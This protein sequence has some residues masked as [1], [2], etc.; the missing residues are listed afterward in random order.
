MTLSKFYKDFL[1]FKRYVLYKLKNGGGGTGGSVA[2]GD[3]TGKP[4]TFAPT[5][6]TTSTT[7]L[8]GNT[9]IPAQFNPIGG[10]GIGLDGTYPNIT[11]NGFSGSY[12]DLSD[13]PTVTN[14]RSVQVFDSVP[15]GTFGT[16]YFAGD[17]VIL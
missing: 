5:I 6:G 4:T 12:N 14:G 3:I 1:Q 8:A 15:T 2:W 16:D 11:F 17:V 13:K 10:T 7:A 9:I